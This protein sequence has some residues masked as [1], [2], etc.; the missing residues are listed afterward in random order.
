MN[1]QLAEYRRRQTLRYQELEEEEE[2]QEQ[3]LMDEQKR[4]RE[5]EDLRAIEEE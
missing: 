3:E 4:Q 2:K 1:A 5:M